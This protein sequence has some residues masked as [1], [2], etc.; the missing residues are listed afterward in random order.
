MFAPAGMTENQTVLTIEV[1]V[2]ASASVEAVSNMGVWVTDEKGVRSEMGA[3]LSHEQP[4]LQVVWL[5]AVAKTAKSF[6]LYFPSGETVD[7]APL[8][9]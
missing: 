1:N 4:K 3:A 5:F 6:L 7:L 2:P 8:L 9:H